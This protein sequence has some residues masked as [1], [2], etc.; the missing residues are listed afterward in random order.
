MFGELLG[1]WAVETWTRMGKPDAFRL[2][3][4]GPGDGTLMSDLLRTVRLAP[5]FVAAC[6]V[7]LIETSWP[8]RAVQKEKLA[9][10]RRRRTGPA[11]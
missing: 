10:A 4:M 11:R 6:E 3:E 2:A 5:D 1:V 8:L 9:G 7:W